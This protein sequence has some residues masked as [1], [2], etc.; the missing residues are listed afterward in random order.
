MKNK[1]FASILTA[2]FIS[3]GTLA[4]ALA[5]SDV[6]SDAS[7]SAGESLDKMDILRAPEQVGIRKVFTKQEIQR[8]CNQY[9]DRLIA[10]YGEVYKVEA[11]TRRVIQNSKTLSRMIAKGVKVQDV[12]GYVI[13]AIP[14]GEPLDNDLIRQSIRSCKVLNG[15][16]VSYSSVDVYFVEGCKRRLLPDWTTYI[17]HR[18]VRGDERGE[19]MALSW[20]EFVA[21]EEGTNVPS[22]VDD[23]FAQLLQGD[24]GVDIIPVDEAC[25]GI[26]GKVVTYYDKMYRVE[27]CSKREILNPGEVLQGF[28]EK[29]T[30]FH[31][32]TSQQWLSL[33]NGAPIGKKKEN[34]P[35]PT[36]KG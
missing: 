23:M 14:E 18:D 21:L 20:E 24:S 5:Q 10:Y 8:F 11:C 33:P 9:K 1:P 3:L 35:K 30:K 36:G 28:V 25:E 13:A 19:I 26:N 22:V 17:N 7:K 15:Q 2:A 16:Y 4:Q 29:T 31:E 12:D 27:K 32:L 6:T 34:G